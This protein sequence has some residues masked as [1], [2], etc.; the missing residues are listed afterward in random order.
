[1]KNIC[2]IT[3][4]LLGS[5]AYANCDKVPNESSVIEAIKSKQYDKAKSLLDTLKSDINIYLKSCDK[6][7]EMFKQTHITLLTCEAKLADLKAEL[8]KEPHGVD[9]SKVPSSSKVVEAIKASDSANIEALYKKYKADASSYIEHCASH[10]EYAIVYDEAMFC[11]EMYDE[12]K[13]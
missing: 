1:M 10:P 3:I 12:W 5:L 7:K 6:S 2:A 13:Q 11:D 4:F 8:N 9:C